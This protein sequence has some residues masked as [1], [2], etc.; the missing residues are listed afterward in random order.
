MGNLFD[1][2]HDLTAD[3]GLPDHW[4]SQLL[5]LG[6]DSITNSFSS[7]FTHEQ[8]SLAAP[9]LQSTLYGFDS[10]LPSAEAIIE[11]TAGASAGSIDLG[12][13]VSNGLSLFSTIEHHSGIPGGA[14]DPNAEPG[15]R[16]R[17]HHYRG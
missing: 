17:K 10:R 4:L 14:P 13:S 11:P 15:S 2:A 1:L 6:Q 5:G 8:P 16:H 7:L 3:L 9:D 12:A